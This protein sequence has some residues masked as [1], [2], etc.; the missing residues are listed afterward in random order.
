MVVAAVVVSLARAGLAAAAVPAACSLALHRL[1]RRGILLSLEV[2]AL[3]QL[4]QIPQERRDQT[5]RHLESRQS[6]AALAAGILPLELRRA[7]AAAAVAAVLPPMEPQLEKQARL[8]R[9][10]LAAMPTWMRYK[11]PSA[12]QEAAVVPGLP[13]QT[14]MSMCLGA[15]EAMAYLAQSAARL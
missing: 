9:E 6:A 8:G 1:L 14:L 3:A 12:P 5:P 13:D 4:L 11:T 15:T 10:T 7:S 2:A